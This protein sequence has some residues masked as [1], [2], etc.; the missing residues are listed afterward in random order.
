MEL[1]QFGKIEEEKFIME[2]KHPSIRIDSSIATKNRLWRYLYKEGIWKLQTQE[3]LNN[4]P[5]KRVSTF[6]RK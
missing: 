2:S 3:H 5:L 4:L 1:T 6:A